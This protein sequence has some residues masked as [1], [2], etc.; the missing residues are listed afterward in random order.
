MALYDSALART[1]S[2]LFSDELVNLTYTIRDVPKEPPVRKRSP[3]SSPLRGKVSQKQGGNDANGAEKASVSKNRSKNTVRTPF[4]SATKSI[5]KKNVT[6]VSQGSNAKIRNSSKTLVS[7]PSVD[8]GS[9]TAL[10]D[11]NNPNIVSHSNFEPPPPEETDELANF[12]IAKAVEIEE[13]PSLEPA[14]ILA[15]SQRQQYFEKP[16]I[17][18]RIRFTDYQNHRVQYG[19]RNRPKTAESWNSSTQ[20]DR[21][22]DFRKDMETVNPH[23]IRPRS[24]R[25]RRELTGK[26]ILSY[27][28]CVARPAMSKRDMKK[29]WN[30]KTTSANFKSALEA[31]KGRR[32]R[33]AYGTTVKVYK[34]VAYTLDADEQLGMAFNGQLGR[35]GRSPLRQAALKADNQ[36]S[37]KAISA[38]NIN[39]SHSPHYAGEVKIID[40]S[41]QRVGAKTFRLLPY[42]SARREHQHIPRAGFVMERKISYDQIK[43]VKNVNLGA[44]RRSR[45]SRHRRDG[46]SKGRSMRMRKEQVIGKNKLN[47]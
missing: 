16:A 20:Y 46:K 14:A 31:Q 36:T 23:R 40:E 10:V 45:G 43:V 29:P 39:R 17:R 26:A 6:E 18:S 2:Q 28:Q 13:E 35:N 7:N 33:Y 8:F 1:M 12:T 3:V 21:P 19:G 37:Q 5:G 4:Q 30:R 25:R 34:G 24:T 38:N 22:N 44:K 11:K 27:N 9:M 15:P 42:Q 47:A 32:S 41:M